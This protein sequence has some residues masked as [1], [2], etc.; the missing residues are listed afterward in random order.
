MWTLFLGILLGLAIPPFYKWVVGIVTKPK[1]KPM[2]FASSM[3]DAEKKEDNIL[4][5]CLT[6]GQILFF[7]SNYVFNTDLKAFMQVA[8]T[9]WQVAGV[10]LHIASLGFLWYK[11]KATDGHGSRG[12][13]GSSILP[14]II[15]LGLAI[16]FS[17]GFNFDYFSLR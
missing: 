16:C 14:W 2:A 10:V 17:T 4:L 12:D 8:G 1:S 9:F 11:A 15:L 13:M 7:L 6:A 5:Y 3:A